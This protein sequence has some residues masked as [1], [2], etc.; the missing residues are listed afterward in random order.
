M[1]ERE[2][3]TGRAVPEIH[4][5]WTAARDALCTVLEQQ[6]Y[7]PELGLLLARELGSP[8]AILRMA[9]YVDQAKP[10]NEEEIIDEMLSIKSDVETWREKKAAR[11]ANMRVNEL[12]Y[13]GLDEE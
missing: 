6:G 1:E 11:Q 10:K 4:A 9:R 3:R 12:K 8:K 13:Y 7:P 2:D 5:E